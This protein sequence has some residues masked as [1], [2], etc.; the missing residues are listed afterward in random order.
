MDKS[1][2]EAALNDAEACGPDNLVNLLA[3]LLMVYHDFDRSVIT[4]L[5]PYLTPEPGVD[6]K[7]KGYFEHVQYL[8]RL[9]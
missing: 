4:R 6:R 5:W 2:L 1:P 8:V 7:N 9:P 3:M